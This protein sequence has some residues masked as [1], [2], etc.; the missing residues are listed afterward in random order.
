MKCPRLDRS[1]LSLLSGLLLV[2]TALSGC[3][4]TA[5]ADL[6]RPL[7][8]QQSYAVQDRIIALQINTKTVT[9][10][11]Q[12]PYQAQPG[13]RTVTNEA[14]ELWVERQGKPLGILVG[15]NRE[16]LYS[17]DQVE[18]PD[19]DTG[20]ADRRQSYRITSSEDPNFRTGLEPKAVFRKS[21]PTDM[22]MIGVW[23]V[24][25]PLAHTVYLELPMPMLPGKRYQITFQGGAVQDL[26]FHY[27]PTQQRSEAVQVSHL[28]FR[29]DD[30]SKVAFVS[31]WMGNGGGLDYPV[32][33]PFRVINQ[34][35]NQTAYQGTLQLQLAGGE[36]ETPRGRNYNNTTTYQL[37]FSALKQPGEYRVCV[38][39]VGCS[40]S[41]PIQDNT[42]R[43]AF[44]VAARGFYHQRSGIA[45]EPPYTTFKRSRPFHPADGLKVYQSKTP[46]LETG[47]GLNWKS[48][49]FTDLVKG[50]TNELVKDAWGGYFDAGDW[51]RRIQ[52][53][54][55]ARSLLE[56]AEL[57]PNYFASV[58]LN[59]PES[60]N[61]LPD[62]VDEALWGVDFFKRLQ[63]PEGGIRGGIESAS[64]PKR[65]E[66]SW[67]E[68]LTVMAYAPDPW[69]SYLYAGAAARAAYVIQQRDPQR[70]AAYRD[71][72]LR[73]IAYADRTAPALN[74]QRFQIRDARNLAA[75]E[76]LRL[77]GDRRWHQVFLETTVFK[78]ASKRPAEWDKHDQ[79]DAAFVYARL[80]K[81]L[82]DAT[83]QQQAIAAIRRE[84]DQSIQT[85]QRTGFGWTRMDPWQPIGW[86]GSYGNP[87]IDSLIRAHVLSGESRYLAAAVRGCQFGAGANPTNMVLTTGLGQRSPQNPLIVDQRILGRQ[88]PPP[89]ITV[90]GP[91]DIHQ[92]PDNWP[93]NVLAEVNF[94]TV[95]KW[96]ISE[97]YFDI[98]GFPAVTEFTVMETMA[99]TA[100]A[101]GYLA[102]RQA[103]P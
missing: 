51:D 62:I 12:I 54:A 9:R 8:V 20:W 96:P 56:L 23:D 44:Y 89:G 38:D 78:D 92:F 3:F 33:L 81:V 82:V 74:P 71:S 17:L 93:T 88:Q 1:P 10:R 72:A 79:R 58:N 98:Y 94:P 21:K 76:M 32:G 47:N 7:K 13:D 45:L 26:S 27:V 53:L 37:D 59:I 63:T 60:K 85:G 69:S 41:F 61:T 28:G 68:S 103:L 36:P 24:A 70:A 67:Q 6:D 77:T 75:V 18:G 83:V 30:P 100:Y 35:T 43:D 29:P 2:S 15:K 57:F 39:T 11:G 46:I 22:P 73:A 66:T 52:H 91:L 14:G 48:D 97:S 86:A 101:W 40:F 87:Q 25:W 19:L 4:P 84:A 65:G 31:T 50:K 99:P 64:H 102:A 95:W 16:I 5:K 42:W 55:I 34:Q 80:P 90:Y 49:N